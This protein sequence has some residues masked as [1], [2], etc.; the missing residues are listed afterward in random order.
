MNATV[1]PPNKRSFHVRAVAVPGGNDGSI[2]RDQ[3]KQVTGGIDC[4]DLGITPLGDQE[5][6]NSWAD[7]TG[8]VCLHG[9]QRYGGGQVAFASDCWDDR[10]KGGSVETLTK[11]DDEN[12]TEQDGRSDFTVDQ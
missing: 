11:A 2:D 6:T 7:N 9:V 12:N 5:P 4:K 10:G 3:D 8:A 1:K